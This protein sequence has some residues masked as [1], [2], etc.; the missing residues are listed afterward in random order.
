MWTT[1]VATID[2]HSASRYCV[3]LYLCVLSIFWQNT[4]HLSVPVLGRGI[5]YISAYLTPLAKW[6]LSPL[7]NVKPITEIIL[8]L[9]VHRYLLLML[10]YKRQSGFTMVMFSQKS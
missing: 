7:R 9:F 5:R 10:P 6:K 4:A 3:L 1:T 2:A 8:I